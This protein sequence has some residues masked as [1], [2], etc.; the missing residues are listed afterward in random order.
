M[1]DN[2]PEYRKQYEENKL[3]LNEKINISPLSV[4]VKSVILT[5][6]NIQDQID[7]LVFQRNVI[8]GATTLFA[9]T[10]AG[11]W[12][13]AWWFGITIPAAIACTTSSVSCGI[14]QDKIGHTVNE[15]REYKEKCVDKVWKKFIKLWFLKF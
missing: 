15:L 14:L 11:F 3:N 8:I 4:E 9:I 1:C 5:N 10:A 6:E 2:F 13:A 7:S 12:A